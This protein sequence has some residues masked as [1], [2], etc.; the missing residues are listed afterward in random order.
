MLGLTYKCSAWH[1][2][3]NGRGR[4]KKKKSG[5]GPLFLVNIKPQ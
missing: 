4:Y 2:L 3:E 1:N 5:L